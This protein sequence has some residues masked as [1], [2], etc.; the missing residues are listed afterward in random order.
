MSSKDVGEIES[1]RAQIAELKARIQQAGGDPETSEDPGRQGEAPADA[2]F[3]A[4]F[5]AL[6]DAAFL[7][8]AAGRL[9]AIN[10]TGERLFGVC[11]QGVIGRS[12]DESSVEVLREDE[13][14]MSPDH[15]PVRLALREGRS[16]ENVVLGVVVADE[17]PLWVRA[18]AVPLTDAAG[19]ITG[20]VL[21]LVDLTETR[22]VDHRRRLLERIA[23]STHEAIAVSD[24]TGR[25][26]YVNPAYE[27]LLGRSLDEARKV[28]YREFYTQESIEVIQR[29]VAPAAARGE[30]WEGT[31][32][33]Y[34]AAGRQRV[35]W[36]RTDGVRDASGG[37]L[38]QFDLMHDVSEEAATRRELEAA[39]ANFREAL[40]SADH[41]LYRLNVKEGRYDYVSPSVERVSGFTPEEF[42]QQGL[43]DMARQVHPEDWARIQQRTEQLRS[44]SGDE[45]STLQVEYRR[46]VK[47]GSYHWFYDSAMCI[48][49]PDGQLEAVVGSAY[50]ITEQKR[51]RQA[52]EQTQGWMESILQAAPIVLFGLEADGTVAFCGGRQDR[53][54]APLLSA[55]DV[56]RPIGECTDRPRELMDLIE[57]ARE[58]QEGAIELSP[59]GSDRVLAIKV[60]AL[61]PQS[62]QA[63]PVVGVA[64]DVTEHRRARQELDE[65]R[66]VFSTF[67]DQFPG[68]AFIKDADS[69]LAFANQTMKDLL[70]ADAWLGKRADEV[71]PDDL[72]ESVLAADRRALEEGMVA[73]EEVVN[74]RWGTPRTWRTC[75]FAIE[76]AG[77]PPLLGGV[78]I[79]VTD[80]KRIEH[81]LRASEQRF[82]SIVETFPGA[83]WVCRNDEDFTPVYLSDR[84]PDIFGVTNEQ[85]L[86]KEVRFLDLAHPA[87]VGALLSKVRSSIETG[88][89]FISEHRVIR[90]DGSV[91]WV[92][93]LGRPVE[94]AGR[95]DR[96]V[97]TTIDITDRK[98]AEDRLRRNTRALQAL[99]QCIEAMIHATDES[100]LL[101]QVCDILVETGGYRLAWAGYAMHD[102]AKS[103]RPVAQA[104]FEEGYL[105]SLKVSWAVEPWGRGP[106][107]L[108]VRTGRPHV[109]KDVQSDPCFVPAREEAMRRG[110]ASSIA[111]PLRS[112]CETFGALNVYAGEANAFDA[113]E[114]GLLSNLAD[115]LAFGI[116]SIRS[117]QA[118]QRAEQE[119][120]TAHERLEQRVRERTAQLEQTNRRLQQEVEHRKQAE[121]ELIDTHRKLMDAGED[122]RKWLANE[123]HDSFGQNLFA[124]ELALS[125]ASRRIDGESP[126]N[127]DIHACVQM[128]EDL[129]R[130]VRSIC[131][132]LYP[133]TLES[134]GLASALEQLAEHCASTG[135]GAT[136]EPEG[137]I[138]ERRLDRD[139]E[140][141]LF[142]VAQEAA[143]NALR[144]GQASEIR[145]SLHMDD[146][147]VQLVV[148][149]DGVG[150]D[151][152]AGS[153]GMGMRT[154]E[155]RA[156]AVGGTLRIDSRPGMTVVRI[157]VPLEPTRAEE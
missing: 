63:R 132:G 119:L 31:L 91:V 155:E 47:D 141:N 86:N 134:H 84:A 121:R 19:A 70:G 18:T 15:W 148:E 114:V 147:S 43:E 83:V 36:Q 97:G 45:R 56:G 74:D 99:S 4:L 120:R 116:L 92:L 60:A 22:Q 150:F 66:T 3:E 42:L 111:L 98:R 7:Y 14:Y 102:Q 52:L 48:F 152:R 109:C 40:E 57:A 5:E 157:D 126:G 110:Y 82:R 89:P 95:F 41:V 75:R 93:E 122:E 2:R 64:F 130:E 71:L 137:D 17:E 154:M 30:S 55:D 13:T 90:P 142:R 59:P 50:D 131:A 106:T 46:K 23:E 35:I 149:D 101:N 69:R 27:R 44:A 20:A 29:E 54:L 146:E 1:L 76:R 32:K 6:T 135:T 123:L 39:R 96:L 133:P 12:I 156:A 100:D 118:R 151:T 53:A 129:I 34:D 77:Q 33:V 113:D 9:I 104:G 11:S 145:I 68:P 94:E 58:G 143:T 51:V 38:Y 138:Q 62:D 81:A 28:N 128:C 85:L 8:D 73:G 67:A 37:L 88:Q 49:G 112:D 24:P 124:L 21:T 144:H 107:G 103:I 10:P 117:R 125:H 140:I 65:V 108:A 80:Q 72:A 79:D 115:E 139:V 78:S 136:F 153:D 61:E 26:V 87:E 105:S 16:V 25:L 127:E